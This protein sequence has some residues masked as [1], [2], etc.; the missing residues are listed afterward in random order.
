[1]GQQPHTR[2]LTFAALGLLQQ[3][4]DGLLRLLEP[5][6]EGLVADLVLA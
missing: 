6:L 4:Q 1:M 3:L 2:G 5:V